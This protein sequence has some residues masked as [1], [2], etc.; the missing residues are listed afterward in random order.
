MP[1]DVVNVGGLF[2]ATRFTTC[3]ELTVMLEVMLLVSTTVKV[4]VRGAVV[5]F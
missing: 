5:G 2:T 4:I 3:C 1:A